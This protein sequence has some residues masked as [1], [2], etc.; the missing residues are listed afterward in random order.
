[1]ALESFQQWYFRRL[2]SQMSEEY[3]GQELPLAQSRHI[4]KEAIAEKSW[5][6]YSPLETNHGILFFRFKKGF[7]KSPKHDTSSH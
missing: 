4:F 2:N 1:M 3:R 6:V 5:V 7:K